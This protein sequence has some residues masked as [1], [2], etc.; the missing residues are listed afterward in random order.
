MSLIRL[1]VDEDAQHHG[2]APALRARGLDVVTAFEA[3]L[4]GAD[5]DAVFAHAV[6]QG[7]ALD[8]FNT[9]GLLSPAQPNRSS[10]RRSTNRPRTGTSSKGN[11][12]SSVTGGG[13][14]G[15][16]AASRGPGLLN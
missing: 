7:R 8:T 9:G 14:A 1:L 16:G 4:T 10:T 11:R 3:G 5:D 12:R 2:L 13:V 6:E 15:A